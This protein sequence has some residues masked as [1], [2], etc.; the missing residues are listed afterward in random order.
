MKENI[1][2]KYIAELLKISVSTVSRALQ[3]HPRIGFKTKEKVKAIANELHYIPNPGAKLL[4]GKKTGTIGVLVPSLNEDFFHIIVHFIEDYFEALGYQCLIFETRD[5]SQ[6]QLK[7]LEKMLERRVEGI[8]ISLAGDTNNYSV[9]KEIERLEIPVVFFDRTPRNLASHKIVNDIKSGALA[10]MQ[11]FS[12]IGC[13][14]VAIINGPVNLE[15]SD[16]RLNAYLE[17][18]YKHNFHASPTYI[19][20]C[21]LTK[22]SVE[23]CM[24][25]LMALEPKPEGI[26]AFNDYVALYAMAKYRN[27]N[28]AQQHDIVFVSAANLPITALMQTPPQA[29]LEL[30]PLK[31][32]AETCKLLENILNNTVDLLDFQSITVETQFIIH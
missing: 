32:A 30:F 13:H 10:S 11:Y 12:D 1:N 18:V 20:S 22:Q 3:N 19:K 28:P 2:L 24:Q 21:D 26:L 27:M 9:F 15:L 8:L 6:R 14:R 17:W 29:S 25:E 4:K 7:Y 31:I 23:T 16:V 5:S